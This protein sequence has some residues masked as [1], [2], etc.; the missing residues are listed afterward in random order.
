MVLHE[1]LRL[2]P[3][4]QVMVNEA[5]QDLKFGDFHVPKGFHTWVPMSKLHQDPRIWGLDAH[6]F[7][8]QRF[9]DGV[10]GSCP[11]PQ[12]FMPF[13]VGPRNCLGQNFA[14]AEL[15]IL[16]A[17]ILSNFSFSL[18]P[19]Y[20]HSPVQEIFVKPKYGVKLLFKKL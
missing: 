20:R 19:D 12:V 1:S 17:L 9:A 11:Q 7:N 6:E 4:V 5:L 2:Y 18:S 16:F 10:S 3:P 13:G 8:P 15:K 14:L